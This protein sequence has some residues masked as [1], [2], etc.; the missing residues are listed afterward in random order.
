MYGAVNIHQVFK[1]VQIYKTTRTAPQLE[2]V[3]RAY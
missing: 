2:I 3:R 1:M